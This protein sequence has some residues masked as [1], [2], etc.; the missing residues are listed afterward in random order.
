MTFSGLTSDGQTI[1][2]DSDGNLRVTGD[3]IV[4]IDGS[5]FLPESSVEVWMFSSPRLLSTVTADSAGRVTENVTLP[6]VLA[7][8]DHRFVLN[9][10]SS[11]GDDALVGLGLIVGYEGGG[12]ST[13][14]K[15]MI[16][17]P[18][19]LAV[20]LGLLIPTAV[21]RRRKDQDIAAV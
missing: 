16:A 9:G 21:R 1:P 18:I 15:L 3:D 6:G 10:Q 20:V 11:S 19:A 12:L 4:S 13:I 14:G 2:L 17:L 7:E 8:G 5:G